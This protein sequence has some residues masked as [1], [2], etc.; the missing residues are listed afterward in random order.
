MFD[1]FFRINSM[2]ARDIDARWTLQPQAMID[3]ALERWQI[4]VEDTIYRFHD[5]LARES[6]QHVLKMRGQKNDDL[7]L[8]MNL[9]RPQLRQYSVQRAS[10]IRSFL[11][12][13]INAELASGRTPMQ[14]RQNIF[15][16]L[17]SRDRVLRVARTEAHTAFERGAWE[18]AN[19]FGVRM[20]KEWVS[21]EDA[22]VRLPHALANGQ[23][24]EIDDFFVVG[25]ENLLYPG[26]PRASARNNVNCRCTVIYRLVGVGDGTNA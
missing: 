15:S 23:V 3:L 4:D 17:S 5:T 12:Q 26:D 18:A 2:L 25:G 21:R 1:A 24:R 10:L 8:L 16:I 6:A 14:V 9:L 22:R 19:S 20:Q 13:R 11:E 7:E